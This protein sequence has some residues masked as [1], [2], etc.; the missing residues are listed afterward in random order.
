[1]ASYVTR[2]IVDIVNIYI[3]IYIYI[4]IFNKA[5]VKTSSE[6]AIKM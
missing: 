2:T 3:Y 6:D 5:L 1:M 4:Y